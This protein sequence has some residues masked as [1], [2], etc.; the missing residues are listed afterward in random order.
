MATAGPD[1]IPVGVRHHRIVG[2]RVRVAEIAW[3][4]AVE[5]GEQM[6]G[7]IWGDRPGPG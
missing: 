1:C 2:D 3:S 4:S 6:R 5:G 7:R